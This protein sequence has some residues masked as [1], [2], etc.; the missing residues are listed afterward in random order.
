[1]D[2]APESDPTTDPL[3]LATRDHGDTLLALAAEAIVEGLRDGA[4]T[5]PDLASQPPPLR[6]EGA[7]FVTLTKAGRLRGCI[8]SVGAH[9]PLALD[10]ALNAWAA[11]RAS[12]RSPRTNWPRWRCR[13]RS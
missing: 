9:R 7:A 3:V 8:G 6:V 1:M 11:T 13:S 4:P 2:K 5:P 10:V 12:P